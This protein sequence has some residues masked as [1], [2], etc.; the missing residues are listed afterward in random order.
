MGK[1][2]NDKLEEFLKWYNKENSFTQALIRSSLDNALTSNTIRSA[3]LHANVNRPKS[4]VM[5]MYRL[6]V[7]ERDTTASA[8][9]T[10]DGTPLVRMVITPLGELALAVISL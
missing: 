2:M 3:S 6:G 7:F 9:Q 8:R 4:L 5:Q 1:I 10:Y